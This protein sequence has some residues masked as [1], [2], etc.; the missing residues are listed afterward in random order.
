MRR[1]VRR[2]VRGEYAGAVH[3]VPPH[4]VVPRAEAVKEDGEERPGF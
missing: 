4:V 2:R 1:D 3:R